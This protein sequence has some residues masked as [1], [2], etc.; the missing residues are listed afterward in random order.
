MYYCIVIGLIIDLLTAYIWG[1]VHTVT[2]TDLHLTVYS[3]RNMYTTMKPMFQVLRFCNI[4]NFLMFLLNFLLHSLLE[5]YRN[6]IRHYIEGKLFFKMYIEVVSLEVWVFL[7]KFLFSISLSSMLKYSYNY[8][9]NIPVIEQFSQC[10]CLD[11]FLLV[12]YH[13][14]LLFISLFKI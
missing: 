10:K 5:L 2:C 11:F 4:N 7:H 1:L 3:L 13:I 14:F 6:V 12:K 9:F 8:Y